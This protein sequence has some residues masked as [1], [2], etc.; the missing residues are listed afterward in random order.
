MDGQPG[1]HGE[2]TVAHRVDGALG[3]HAA[4]ETEG[5]DT[6]IGGLAREVGARVGEY[7]VIDP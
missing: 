7:R 1:E 2:L 5:G 6:Q 4:G 3:A